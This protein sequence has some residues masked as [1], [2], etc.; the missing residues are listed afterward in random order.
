MTHNSISNDQDLA[1]I[2]LERTNEDMRKDSFAYNSHKRACI[3]PKNSQRNLKCKE[4]FTMKKM[5]KSFPVLQ[6][7]SAILAFVL[8]RK[9]C[10]HVL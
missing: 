9:A 10:F 7:V 4:G 1:L 8:Y 5:S 2:F 3:C 6:P